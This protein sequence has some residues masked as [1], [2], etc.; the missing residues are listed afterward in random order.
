MSMPRVDAWEKKL[1]KKGLVVVAVSEE[2]AESVARFHAK[3][4]IGHALYRADGIAGK[5]YSTVVPTWV[6][7]DKGGIVRYV[8]VGAGSKLDGIEKQVVALLK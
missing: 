7:V 3:E 1:G 4:K 6:V 8:D 2:P 5:L